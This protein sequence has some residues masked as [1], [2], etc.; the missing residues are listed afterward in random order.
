MS[1][2]QTRAPD[3]FPT[4]R[5]SASNLPCPEREGMSWCVSRTLP[6]LKDEGSLP[7]LKAKIAGSPSRT[8][9]SMARQRE[10]ANSVRSFPH[11]FNGIPEF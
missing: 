2:Q 9:S 4:R 7:F 6:S 10:G 11:G 3:V 8:V 1:C 5:H